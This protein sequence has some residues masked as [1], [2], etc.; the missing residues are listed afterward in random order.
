MYITRV[1]KWP[2]VR[3]DE[4]THIHANDYLY[5]PL[6]ALPAWILRQRQTDGD[7]ESTRREGGSHALT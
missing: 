4:Y 2:D 5:A 6:T 3:T 7:R 1:L